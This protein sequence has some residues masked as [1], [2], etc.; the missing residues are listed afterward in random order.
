MKALLFF[1][2]L[3]SVTGFAQGSFTLEPVEQFPLKAN[4]FIGVD[5]LGS[6]YSV[7]NNTLFK[8]AGTE[9]FQYKDFQ[10]GVPG[11]VDLLNPLKITL[12]YPAYQTAVI[13]DNKLNEIK[14]ISFAMKP[15]FL[16][17]KN[18]TTAND[19][20]LWVFNE[21]SQQLELYNFRDQ[22]NKVLSRPISE[23]YQGQLSD[24]NYCY[25]FTETQLRLYNIYGSLLRRISLEN[26][27]KSS[28]S[29]ERLMV[30]SDKQL[31]LFSQQ[32]EQKDAVKTPEITIKDLFL[33]GEFLYIYD[34]EI[35]HKMKLIKSQN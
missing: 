3:F 5:H 12:F 20:R 29:G 6:Y 18:A 14:R 16:N 17:I 8:K 22:I 34:G 2:V 24:Y 1:I 27:E 26:I 9:V 25:V 31:N 28:L 23:T 7:S 11:A 35:I 13:L 21:D 10:L 4:R 30:L 32:L 19:N 15:P 33:S